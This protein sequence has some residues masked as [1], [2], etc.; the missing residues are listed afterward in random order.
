MQGGNHSD[1][2]DKMCVDETNENPVQGGISSRCCGQSLVNSSV[3]L[4]LWAKAWKRWP[5]GSKMGIGPDQVEGKVE[6]ERTPHAIV[7]KPG[8]MMESPGGVSTKYQ[9]RPT[10]T[11]SCRLSGMRSRPRR[12]RLKSSRGDSDARWGWRT[13]AL[14]LAS[15]NDRKI[16]S[17]ELPSFILALNF[18]LVSNAR[19]TS[20]ASNL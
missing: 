17:T 2:R 20:T 8:C 1:Q 3:G 5:A 4:E 18:I 6:A 13:T 7:L 15:R 9:C 11:N 14:N 10:Q 19:P 12:R 16:Y